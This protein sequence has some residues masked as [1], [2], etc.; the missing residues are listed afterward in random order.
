MFAANTKRNYWENNIFQSRKII[1]NGC[2][3]YSF[4]GNP[5]MGNACF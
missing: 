4:A 3:I 1:A 2:D 5:L